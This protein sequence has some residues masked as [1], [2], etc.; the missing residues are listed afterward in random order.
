MSTIMMWRRA[1]L[2]EILTTRRAFAIP[3]ALHRALTKRSCVTHSRRS[4][5][6]LGVRDEGQNARPSYLLLSDCRVSHRSGAG[7]FEPASVIFVLPPN[8]PS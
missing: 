1:M 3:A 2:A 8:P 4:L 6:G 7:A 5:I